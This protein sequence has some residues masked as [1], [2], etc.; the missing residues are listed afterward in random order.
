MSESTPNN[1]FSF[2]VLPTNEATHVAR[3]EA[4][5]RFD[6]GDDSVESELLTALTEIVQ[7]AV[8]AHIDADNDR[9]IDITFFADPASCRVVDSGPGFD[10]EKIRNS[11]PD[12]SCP[13]GRGLLISMAFVPGMIVTTGPSGTTIDLPF[14][15]ATWSPGRSGT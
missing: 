6:F 7:N 4:R 1:R 13:T 11:R 15:G 2:S 10:W 9:Q 3:A 12:P 14:D 8:G 5:R